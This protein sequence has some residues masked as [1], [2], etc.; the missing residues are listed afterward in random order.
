MAKHR[1]DL[2]LRR[3]IANRAAQLITVDGMNDYLAA[4]KK[5]ANQLGIHQSRHFPSNEEIEQALQSYQGLFQSETQPA[6]LLELRKNA[7]QAMIL[8]D[9]Y[10]PWLTGPVLNGTASYNSDIVLH[11]YTDSP[12][13][14]DAL[15]IDRKIPFEH[16]EKRARFPQ[17]ASEYYPGFQFLVK[18]ITITIMIFPERRAKHSP[19]S[20]MDNKPMP[21]MNRES[22]ERLI[23]DS[24]AQTF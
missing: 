11:V 14:I 5:A 17:Q 8:L 18:D 1:S 10:S 22:L 24:T 20:P 3:E 21:R 13:R 12:E 2:N 19:M 9:E 23:Q 6:V 15:L 7:L 16:I 4:K